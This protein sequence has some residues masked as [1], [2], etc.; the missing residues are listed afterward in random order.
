[1]SIIYIYP[2][3]VD[4]FA[5]DY[6]FSKFFILISMM[7]IEHICFTFSSRNCFGDVFILGVPSIVETNKNGISTYGNFDVENISGNFKIRWVWNLY[8]TLYKPIIGIILLFTDLPVNAFCHIAVTIIIVEKFK[9]YIG[10]ICGKFDRLYNIYKNE[11]ERFQ[12]N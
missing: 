5:S 3:F 10:R 9:S 6:I 1:M 7:K 8:N 4:F 11:I 12:V 2:Y